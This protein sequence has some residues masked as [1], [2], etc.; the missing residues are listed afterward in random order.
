MKKLLK[1]FLLLYSINS[2]SQKQVITYDLIKHEFVDSSD[3]E[4]SLCETAPK[5]KKMQIKIKNI[6]LF[7]F[8]PSISYAGYI[9]KAETPKVLTDVFGIGNVT[10]A[11][12]ILDKEKL[13]DTAFKQQFDNKFIGSITK[14]A[15]S[16]QLNVA[17]TIIDK[18]NALIDPTIEK[19]SDN[20]NTIT[21]C[22]TSINDLKALEKLRDDTKKTSTEITS[23][24]KVISDNTDNKS[25]Y[26]EYRRKYQDLDKEIGITLNQKLEQLIINE[27][28]KTSPSTVKE[29][30]EIRTIASTTANAIT[31]KIKKYND[32][33]YELA[34]SNKYMEMFEKIADLKTKLSDEKNFEYTSPEFSISG[35]EFDISIAVSPTEGNK[36]LRSDSIGHTFNV[37]KTV[38]IDFSTGL[39]GLFGSS[40]EN[41]YYTKSGAD[42]LITKGKNSNRFTP[43]LSAF[44][45]IKKRYSLNYAGALSI[46]AGIDPTDATNIKYMLGYSQFFGKKS[47]IAISAGIAFDK[48]RYLK[49]NYSSYS[50]NPKYSSINIIPK[51]ELGKPETLTELKLVP[52]AF[53]GITYNLSR[54]RTK[55]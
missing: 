6:N 34:E 20:N 45:H 38:K 13:F 32:K 23:A 31:E 8:K 21:V 42:T 27:L 1:V 53:I 35:E 49:D 51:P 46:G 3:E 17:S 48:K 22:S 50:K 11:N 12:V 47:L 33:L 10:T 4:I 18:I 55:I 14:A 41:Y 19:I 24:A 36:H 52:S 39:V 26:Q 15:A 44:I 5:G 37:S 16:Q 30:L 25:K 2:Y 9:Y 54:T 29:I 28:V 7:V 43:A 40:N